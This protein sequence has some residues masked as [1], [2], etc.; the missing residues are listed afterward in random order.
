MFNCL[1]TRVAASPGCGHGSFFFLL[2][3]PWVLVHVDRNFLLY[4]LFNHGN[5]LIQG[6][7]IF[8]VMLYVVLYCTMLIP[9]EI[10]WPKLRRVISVEI[11]NFPNMTR[12][13]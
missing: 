8:Q 2:K 9:V 7:N 6:R 4:S 12:F 13:L 1:E 3:M 10:L 11:F 5:F